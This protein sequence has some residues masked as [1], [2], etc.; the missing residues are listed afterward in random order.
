MFYISIAFKSLKIN[1]LEIGNKIFTLE[2]YFE[3]EQNS[4]KRHEFVEGQIIPI[5]QKTKFPIG[6]L[7]VCVFT[8]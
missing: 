2:E 7:G 6:L 1:L 8:F 5:P 4:E 3:F